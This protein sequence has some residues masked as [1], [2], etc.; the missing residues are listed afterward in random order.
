MQEKIRIFLGLLVLWGL[1]VAAY[2]TGTWLPEQLVDQL[3]WS[4]VSVTVLYG[5]FAIGIR[6]FV[7][8][9]LSDTR[10][11]YS[12]RKATNLAW[13]FVLI[14]VLLWIWVPDPQALLVAYGLVAAGVAFALQ[15]IIKNFAG[16]LIIFFNGQFRVG[17]R[18]Q[19]QNIIGDVIDIGLFD[20]RLLEIQGW[21]TADQTTGRIVTIPNGVVLNQAVHN[22][23]HQHE[24]I[25]DELSLVV[26]A[27][28]DWG[29]AMRLLGEI[30]TEH[31]KE[32]IDTA[33]ASL[34]QLQ[35]QYFVEGRE[36]EPRVYIL[37][38]DHGYQLTVRY[39]VNARVRRVANS[40][41]WG[42]VIR[43]FAEHKHIAIAPVSFA[44]AP[45]PSV[46]AD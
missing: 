42:H 37:N 32:Y 5:V 16:G 25:W 17:D 1:V 45:Y 43:V 24:F 10:A 19:I 27:E 44:S 23:T 7:V 6:E 8:T 13:S 15:D 20:T 2:V 31:T 3:L 22:Y 34:D 28:S 40:N 12:V 11:R 36:T 41:I 30:A 26:T 39:V 9:K 46:A 21:I 4:V 38:H 29:E 14:L 33:E 18:I 35:K